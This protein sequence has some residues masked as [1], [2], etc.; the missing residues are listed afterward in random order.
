MTTT[1]SQALGSY[2]NWT[3]LNLKGIIKYRKPTGIPRKAVTVWK[4][5]RSENSLKGKAFP[6]TNKNQ[7]SP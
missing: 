6:H 2:N 1:M 7:H 4:K 5:R 3:Q